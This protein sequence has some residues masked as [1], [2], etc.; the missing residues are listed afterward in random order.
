MP[1]KVRISDV[2]AAVGVSNAAVSAALNDVESARISAETRARVREAA[3]RLGYAP[4]NL[5]RGLRL[6]RSQ[7][8][9]FLG[10]T[11]ATT[12]YAG[13]MILGA[14]DAALSAGRLI[15]V[16]NTEGDPALEARA[17]TALLQ[18]PVDGLIY[19]TMFH[20]KVEMPPR[21]RE[22]PVVLLDAESVDPAVSSVVP[23][24]AAGAH[25]AVSEL[26]EHGHRR[27]GFV[28]NR[29]PIP[30]T[31]ERLRGYRAALR[32][33]G[34]AFDPTL[35]AA[36]EPSAAG[37]FHAARRLLERPDRPTGLFCFRDFMTMGVYRAAAE[38]GMRI[39]TDLSVV[40]FDNME[41]IATGLFPKLT[42]VQLPHYEM[43][44]WAVRQL[45]AVTGDPPGP[46]KQVKLAGPLV[47]R[48][49][50]APPPSA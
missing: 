39:P 42:T 7:M 11:V 36:G 50:V 48:D 17:L 9:G 43:G 34:V 23:D 30:A 2:A 13:R 20:R 19:A 49:S 38:A 28:T 27:I 46:A 44:A 45:L 8:L 41:V 16:M 24:E 47:R 10:D 3:S 33:A 22:T 32:E 37:G 4:N 21:L 1:G 6:Q 18:H 40:S 25:A 31:G 5:A 26:L 14:Q 15:V 35:V 29:E 12:P